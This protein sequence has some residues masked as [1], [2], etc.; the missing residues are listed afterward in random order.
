MKD[1]ALDKLLNE[2]GS[3]YMKDM[4][5]FYIR[6]YNF[7]YEEKYTKIIYVD[8]SKIG[9]GNLYNKWAQLTPF[10]VKDAI[11]WK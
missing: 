4:R 7:Y 11:F 3:Q 6:L 10:I 5:N 1:N 2:Y 9:I 8:V